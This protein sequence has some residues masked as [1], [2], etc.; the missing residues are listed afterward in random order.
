MVW[1]PLSSYVHRI[2]LQVM[3]EVL[4][5]EHMFAHSLE[6][7]SFFRLRQVFTALGGVLLAFIFPVLDVS[8]PGRIGYGLFLYLSLIAVSGVIIYACYEEKLL[9][10]LFCCITGYSV[11]QLASSLNSFVTTLFAVPAGSTAGISCACPLTFWPTW[12]A[13]GSLPG[14]IKRRGASM[15]TIKSSSF[16]PGLCPSLRF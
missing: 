5:A 12:A 9:G 6:R 15:W 13:M 7:R 1:C 10:V 3:I 8:G 11:H 14:R 16:C 2:N 4:L